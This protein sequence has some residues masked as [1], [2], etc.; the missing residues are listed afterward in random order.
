LVASFAFK[1]LFNSAENFGDIQE[2]ESVH[3]IEIMPE[4]NDAKQTSHQAECTFHKTDF[5]VSAHAL[6]LSEVNGRCQGDYRELYS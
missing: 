3:G 2:N 4:V 5:F 6:T 1:P